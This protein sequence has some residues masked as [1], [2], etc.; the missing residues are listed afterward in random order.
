[1]SVSIARD[2]M[3]LSGLAAAVAGTWLTAGLGVAL[4]VLGVVLYL[5]YELSIWLVRI[6]GR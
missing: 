6:G 5:L 4:I 3:V 1:M 2:L